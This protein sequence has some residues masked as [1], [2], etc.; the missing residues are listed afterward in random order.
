LRA[1]TRHARGERERERENSDDEPVV[2]RRFEMRFR[3]RELESATE[4]ERERERERERRDS[5]KKDACEPHLRTSS[6]RS[7]LYR[8]FPASLHRSAFCSATDA[9]CVL[10]RLWQWCNAFPSTRKMLK[11]CQ[12]R[13]QKNASLLRINLWMYTITP[14]L[15]TR[16]T[17]LLFWLLNASLSYSL[18]LS[19]FYVLSCASSS[20]SLSRRLACTLPFSTFVSPQY[21]YAKPLSLPLYRRFSSLRWLISPTPRRCLPWRTV[22]TFRLRFGPF[23]CAWRFPIF[24]PCCTCVAFGWGWCERLCFA[25]LRRWIGS[26]RLASPWSWTRRQLWSLFVG[27]GGRRERVADV[28]VETA[29]NPRDTSPSKRRGKRIKGGETPPKQHWAM[30]AHFSE[31]SLA[32]PLA[33]RLVVE[34]TRAREQNNRLN[35]FASRRFHLSSRARLVSKRPPLSFRLPSKTSFFFDAFLREKN[36]KNAL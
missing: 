13:M 35:A 33:T 2:S 26:R 19:L 4:K 9:I 32:R 15:K 21:S 12:Y 22:T 14:G 18:S 30:R 28:S 24:E 31:T 17:V 23:W 3:K 10:F 6:Y 36:K 11:K 34:P 8:A 7:L 29:H 25:W 20:R 16:R 1:R 5:E 27:F